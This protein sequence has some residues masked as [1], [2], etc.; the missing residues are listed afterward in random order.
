MSDRSGSGGASGGRDFEGLL[1]AVAIAAAAIAWVVAASALVCW[2]FAAVGLACSL[3]A[4]R[5][6]WR[7]ETPRGLPLGGAV[8]GVTLLAFALPIWGSH[9]GE[10]PPIGTPHERHAHP[11]WELGHVH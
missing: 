10:L 11:I 1:C 9:F 7:R 6:H 5:A 3:L 4:A 8:A 2:A